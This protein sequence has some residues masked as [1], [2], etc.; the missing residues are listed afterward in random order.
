MLPE[1]VTVKEGSWEVI[2]EADF[3]ESLERA[4]VWEDYSALVGITVSWM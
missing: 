2:R 3:A 4:G 1:K